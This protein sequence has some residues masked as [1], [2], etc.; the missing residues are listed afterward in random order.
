[1]NRPE[2]IATVLMATFDKEI[3]DRQAFEIIEKIKLKRPQPVD[4]I[5]DES[6]DGI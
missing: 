1:M 5:V 6:V 4:G 3:T 2:A